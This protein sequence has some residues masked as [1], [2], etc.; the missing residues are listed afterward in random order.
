LV[1]TIGGHISDKI[2][3][4]VPYSRRLIGVLTRELMQA[5]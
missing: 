1:W 2:N 5:R 4:D 3:V